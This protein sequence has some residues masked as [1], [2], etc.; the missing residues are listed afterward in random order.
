MPT[1]VAPLK[2]LEAGKKVDQMLLENMC[3][4]GPST[5]PSGPIV[6]EVSIGKDSVQG[7]AEVAQ[8]VGKLEPNPITVLEEPIISNNR[9]DPIVPEQYSINLNQASSPIKKKKWKRSTREMQ[10]RLAAGLLASPL[11]RKLAASVSTKKMSRR[12]SLSPSHGKSGHKNISD[13]GLP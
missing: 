9:Q 11:Q 12:N 13:K 7:Q 2:S 10:N 6:V 5:G 8:L 4:D 1:V 3:I